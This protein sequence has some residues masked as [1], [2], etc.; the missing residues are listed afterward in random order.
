MKTAKIEI[1]AGRKTA[2]VT[3]SYQKWATKGQATVTGDKVL[4]D[5]FER[6]LKNDHIVYLPYTPE[7]EIDETYNFVL[8]CAR[9]VANRFNGEVVIVTEPEYPAPEVDEDAGP[10]TVY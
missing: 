8:V 7:G 5:A 9:I 10:D 6:E 4:S 1:T 3:F 2:E